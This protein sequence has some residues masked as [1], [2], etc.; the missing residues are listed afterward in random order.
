MEILNILFDAALQMSM[1]DVSV[2]FVAGYGTHKVRYWWINKDG[3]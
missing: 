2:G 1:I 3:K